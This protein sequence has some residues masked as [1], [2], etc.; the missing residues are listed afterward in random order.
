M[1]KIGTNLETV[2][3][4][5]NGWETEG[6]SGGGNVF[7]RGPILY[8]YGYHFPMAVRHPSGLYI[9]N[10]D[11]YS[12]T[13]SKHQSYLFSTIPNN[14]R[15]QIPFSALEA[16]SNALGDRLMFYGDVATKMIPDI[17]VIDW[18]AERY[19][20]TGRFDKDGN[21]IYEHVL[22][23]VLFHYKEHFYVTGMDPSGRDP[24]GN[25]FLT[26]LAQEA[27]ML[28]GEPTTIAE[29]YELLKPPIIRQLAEDVEV[30]RQGEWFFVGR[31]NY[32]F[33]KEKIEK[34]YVLQHHDPEREAR[35]VATEGILF[36]DIQYVRG[37]VK[38]TDREHKQLKLY[39]T[40]TKPKD[41]Q[42]YRVF[43]SVQGPSWGASGSVD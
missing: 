26:Q 8:S 4:Y 22:G 2:R 34:N 27:V 36:G 35:H 24:R 33:P 31:G 5:V 41:R 11:R 9:V 28:H 42:W 20:D 25:F 1:K 7:F 29:A 18:E 19:L 40:G 21:T 10:G 14:Q 15:V 32:P 39:E 6:E 38:H 13:T 12:P 23:G 17:E 16:M 43:E 3:A 37:I 30:H